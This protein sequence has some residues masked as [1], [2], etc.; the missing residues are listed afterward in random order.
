[1]LELTNPVSHVT[2]FI[3]S[4]WSIFQRRVKFYPWI[5]YRIGSCFAINLWAQKNC[6]IFLKGRF[7][8]LLSN[9]RSK[10]LEPITL[11]IED[12][13]SEPWWASSQIESW[14]PSA[15][16]VEVPTYLFVLSAICHLPFVHRLIIFAFFAWAGVEPEPLERL[17]KKYFAQN[18]FSIVGIFICKHFAIFCLVQKLSSAGHPERRFFVDCRFDSHLKIVFDPIPGLSICLRVQSL[19]P[20]VWRQLFLTRSG[21][22]NCSENL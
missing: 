10:G 3:F 18:C 15:S 20:S 19:K 7:W 6:Q 16:I 4:D 22:H 17:P 11:E 14:V 21:R 12:Y 8:W 1:M 9:S 13:T 2:N 5:F